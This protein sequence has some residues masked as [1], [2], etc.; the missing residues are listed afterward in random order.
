MDQ[1]ISIL[2]ELAETDNPN[3][4]F[5]IDYSKGC[6][7]LDAENYSDAIVFLTAAEH[8][9]GDNFSYY[10]LATTR[11]LS[12]A[13]GKQEEWE[14]SKKFC[15]KAIQKLR[16]DDGFNKT[17][18]FEY[19]ELLGELA[20]IHWEN[21][22]PEKACGAMYGLVMKLVEDDDIENLRYQ[23]VFNKVGHGLGW[24]ISMASN[25]V[26]PEKT[27]AGEVYAPVQAGLFG[28][29][30]ENVGKYVPP[31]GY[32]K[33]LM[34]WQLGYFAFE[35]GL[36]RMAKGIIELSL[37]QTENENG[38]GVHSR[39]AYIFL[40]TL[41]IMLGTPRQAL[42]YAIQARKNFTLEGVQRSENSA[43]YGNIEISEISDR[44]DF[45]LSEEEIKKC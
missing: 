18:G 11:Q 35:L 12:I 13:L 27:L 37:L 33:S 25:G 32:L 36:F 6:F 14:A 39:L 24:F 17:L 23:E 4:S 28:I 5:L 3:S 26:P 7:A 1:A 43:S 42:L 21:N 22:A 19:L 15:K 41:E 16:L 40:T 45:D 8:A 10:R 9:K 29:R 34:L 31:L 38:K 20:I 30:R 44:K 2:S